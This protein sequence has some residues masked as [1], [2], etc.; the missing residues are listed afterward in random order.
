MTL[1]QIFSIPL[2]F[3]LV[4]NQIK[5]IQ[6]KNI[7]KSIYEFRWLTIAAIAILIIAFPQISEQIATFFGIS[8]GVDFVV[9]VSLIWLLYKNKDDSEKIETLQSQVEKLVRDEAI[10]QAKETSEK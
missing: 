4:I 8:R 3:V 10:K 5:K 2:L 9:Y 6:G 7:I 1:F